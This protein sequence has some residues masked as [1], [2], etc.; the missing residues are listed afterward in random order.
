MINFRR[1]C[2]N[3][4]RMGILSTPNM[5]LRKNHRLIEAYE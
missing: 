2:M 5:L 3:T 4:I 1:L